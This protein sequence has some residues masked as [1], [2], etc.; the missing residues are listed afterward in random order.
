LISFDEA[1]L[2]L[3]LV[4]T[5][6]STLPTEIYRYLEYATDPQIAALSVI[7]ILISL[8][9]VVVLE[10]LIGLRKAL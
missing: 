10:R 9:V 7:L 5:R 1:T 8:A 3:F 4:S 2:S 6:A